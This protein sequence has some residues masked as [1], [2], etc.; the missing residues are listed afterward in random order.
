MQLKSDNPKA[1]RLAIW[2][3]GGVALAGFGLIAD[4]VYWASRHDS[5]D[6]E[7]T[8][9][10]IDHVHGTLGCGV[11]AG[12]LVAWLLRR[13]GAFRINH[14]VPLTFAGGYAGLVMFFFVR[15]LLSAITA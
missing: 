10:S 4:F 12:L 15:F 11:V 7:F 8:H 6:G 14:I 5:S 9:Y 2:I 13:A 3:S 1:F